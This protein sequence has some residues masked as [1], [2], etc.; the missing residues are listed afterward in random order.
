MSSFTTPTRATRAILSGIP[1]HP[2]EDVTLNNIQIWYR[3]GGTKAQA[4]LMPPEKRGS[5]P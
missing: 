3:G 1:G 2:I 5:L 4:A